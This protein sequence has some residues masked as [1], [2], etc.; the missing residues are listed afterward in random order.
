MA[1]LSQEELAIGNNEG[2]NTLAPGSTA[3]IVITSFAPFKFGPT[4]EK[5]MPKYIAKDAD[6]GA[7]Y[8][9]VGFKFHDAIKPLNDN[10]VAEATVIRVECLDNGTKYP[11]YQLTVVA[12]AE[13]ATAASSAPF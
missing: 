13:K 3:N 9:F 5:T 12:G 1:L 8:E 11:D 7:D 10:I 4:K 2:G 6:T